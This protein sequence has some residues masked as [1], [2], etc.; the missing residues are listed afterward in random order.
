MK[1]Q[2]F[3]GK[4]P[5]PYNNCSENEMNM[6]IDEKKAAVGFVTIVS[7]FM[8]VLGAVGMTICFLFLWSSSHI[9]VMGAGMGFIAGATMMGSGLISL[10]IVSLKAK[11]K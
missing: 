5:L 6:E 1:I 4:P 3:P 11:E 10:A 2:A 7:L 9:D 8:L